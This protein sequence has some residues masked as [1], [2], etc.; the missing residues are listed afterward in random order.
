M[1]IAPAGRRSVRAIGIVATVSA[2][3]PLGLVGCSPAATLAN[4]VSELHAAADSDLLAL[5]SVQTYTVTR[6]KLLSPE[7]AAAF[8]ESLGSDV[9]SSGTLTLSDGA[10]TAAEFSV[11]AATFPEASFTLTEPVILSH[12]TETDGT[13]TAV[14]T[15]AFDGRERPKTGIEL[16]PVS[17]TPEDAR[18]DVRV[19]VPNS[20]MAAGSVLPFDEISATLDLQAE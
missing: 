16:T 6:A 7:S 9:A 10:I 17:I 19:R 12:S 18:F 20:P 1:T 14:G 5:P 4:Q 15:L 11:R 13:V 8:S 3:L 2:A